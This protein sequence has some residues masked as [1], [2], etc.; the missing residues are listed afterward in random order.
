MCFTSYRQ[1]VKCKWY[2]N[3]KNKTNACSSHVWLKF[4][5]SLVLFL[6][7]KTNR[8][9][10]ICYFFLLAIIFRLLTHYTKL[11]NTERRLSVGFSCH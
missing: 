9:D 5:H 4:E 10:V 7:A 8:T 11:F 2:L 3:I 1:L 6:I